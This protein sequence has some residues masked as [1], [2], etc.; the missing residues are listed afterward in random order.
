MC[1]HVAIYSRFGVS[2]EILWPTE[3]GEYFRR[4]GWRLIRA[5]SIPDAT[6]SR[7]LATLVQRGGRTALMT[8]VLTVRFVASMGRTEVDDALSDHGLTIVRRLGFGDNLYT[9]SVVG[10]G[11]ADTAAIAEKLM[12][13]PCCEMAEPV[14]VEQIGERGHRGEDIS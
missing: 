1:E 9:A 6:M 12:H 14:Y 3:E 13:L 2:G 4:A 11:V 5:A 8:A 10:I 7:V